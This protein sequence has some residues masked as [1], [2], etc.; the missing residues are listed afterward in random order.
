MLQQM[1]A[2]TGPTNSMTTTSASQ[3]PWKASKEGMTA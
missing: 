2:V 1:M 3:K